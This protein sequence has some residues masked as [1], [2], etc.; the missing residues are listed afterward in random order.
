MEKNEVHFDQEEVVK[1]KLEEIR[2]AASRIVDF[3]F[4]SAT[5]Q[6][7]HIR[8]GADQEAR[9][10]MIT[11]DSHGLTPGMRDFCLAPAQRT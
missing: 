5:E 8:D 3:L 7:K 1:E 6:E 10:E 2:T 9:L 11:L 4:P